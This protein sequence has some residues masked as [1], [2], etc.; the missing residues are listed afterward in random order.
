[1]IPQEQPIEEKT[2]ATHD[3]VG[4]IVY[5]TVTFLHKN[6]DTGKWFPVR[7]ITNSTGKDA[8]TF[9]SDVEQSKVKVESDYLDNI[10]RLD[11]AIVEVDSKIAK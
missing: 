2:E 5:Q 8:T 9:K 6:I 1:M 11:D 10:K 7:R 3:V 4:D